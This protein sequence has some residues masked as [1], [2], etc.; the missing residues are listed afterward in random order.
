MTRTVAL[1][2][3]ALSC[4]SGLAEV[5][6]AQHCD[7]STYP[8]SSASSRFRTDADGTVTDT[9]SR[10]MWMR[11]SAGQTW[12][13][14]HCSGPAGSMS[15]AAAQAMADEVNRGG[16][17]FYND[18][19][20]PRMPELAS[21]AERQCA[22]PRINLEVFPDT[23]SEFYWTATSR[24]GQPAEAFGFALSFGDEGFRYV[25]RSEGRHVRLV[26]NAL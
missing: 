24:S 10:L 18:W 25:D 15:Y 5:Q 21:I 4:L 11:C 6:A 22:Q 26:R 3:A 12:T 9:R 8:L 19:R 2:I 20:V 23:P 16:T 14:D 1:W 17:A 13:G 7:T